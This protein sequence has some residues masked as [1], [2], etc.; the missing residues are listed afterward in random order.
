MQDDGLDAQAISMDH[1]AM[2][3]SDPKKNAAFLK[4]FGEFTPQTLK[5]AAGT[6]QLAQTAHATSR[7][8][9]HHAQSQ[10]AIARKFAE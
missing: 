9:R 1:D 8:A 10:A 5:A 3:A 2:L 4:V 6:T 7:H